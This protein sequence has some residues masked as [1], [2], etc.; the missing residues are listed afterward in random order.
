MRNSATNHSGMTEAKSKQGKVTPENLEE[1]AKLRP[2]WEA[3]KAEGRVTSQEAFGA[4]ND[5]GNQA[6]VGFFLN[7]KTALSMK[8]AIGFA[9]GLGCRVDAFSPRL[10][11]EIKGI[12]SAAA[13]GLRA[14]LDRLAGPKGSA[15]VNNLTAESWV[16][17]SVSHF[18]RTVLPTITWEDAMRGDELPTEFCLVAPDD[19]LAPK[20][21][22]GT[23]I[24]WSTTKPPKLGAPILIRTREGHVYMRL[25]GERPLPGG[26]IAAPR[27]QGPTFRTFDSE[28]DGLTILAVFDGLRGD[29][30]DF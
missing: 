21:R 18:E 15:P 6:A 7:G 27:T 28:K 23:K 13:P 12:A 26:F 14:G 30:E 24:I 16:D 8:A 10:A 19:A 25:M 1:A 5:I 4:A 3:A 22:A 29:Y 17:Q 2:L 9:R 11:K 20:L